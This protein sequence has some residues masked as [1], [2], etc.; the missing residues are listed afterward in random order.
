MLM[1]K[2]QFNLHTTK[3]R[4]SYTILIARTGTCVA[5]Y[6]SAQTKKVDSKKLLLNGLIFS[7]HGVELKY[8]DLFLMNPLHG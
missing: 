3:C 8:V 5:T 1:H 6:E 2:W 4:N 7:S